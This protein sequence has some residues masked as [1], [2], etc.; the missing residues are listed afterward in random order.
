MPTK[1]SLLTSLKGKSISLSMNR[2]N[3]AIDISPATI[4][5][6]ITYGTHTITL[7]GEDIFEAKTKQGEKEY[8]SIAHVRH[9]VV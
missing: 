4:H 2:N 8:F 6:G 3:S 7:I 9:I 1:K 5:Q